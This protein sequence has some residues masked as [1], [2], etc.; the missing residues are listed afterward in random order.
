[1]KKIISFLMI[2]AL[3]LNSMAFAS[4]FD[5]SNTKNDIVEP[6]SIQYV[7]CAEFVFASNEYEMHKR[8]EYL[9]K[10]EADKT[11]DSWRTATWQGGLAL[12]AG[13]WPK[14]PYVFTTFSSV[15]WFTYSEGRNNVA[16]RIDTAED[17]VP[18]GM[19]LKV[20]YNYSFPVGGFNPLPVVSTSVVSNYPR[21]VYN[22]KPS[23]MDIGYVYYVYFD[24]VV[25][26]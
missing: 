2:V 8:I 7:K 6:L 20:E 19:L 16:S 18:D 24:H 10:D 26:S 25:I 1:M 3:F 9:T 21:S 15:L 4:P 17:S 5:L 13:I 14:A 11:A 22:I 23:N 12:I